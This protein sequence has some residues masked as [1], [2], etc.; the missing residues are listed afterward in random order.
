[1]FSVNNVKSLN[2]FYILYFLL[3]LSFFSLLFGCFFYFGVEVSRNSVLFLKGKI[4]FFASLFSY[5]Y[6]HCSQSSKHKVDF[7]FLSTHTLTEQ[8]ISEG[9]RKQIMNCHFIVLHFSFRFGPVVQNNHISTRH[10]LMTMYVL[11]CS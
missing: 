4:S 6:I 9:N 10:K 7:L 1:M 2:W 5:W 8:D 11:P 3:S